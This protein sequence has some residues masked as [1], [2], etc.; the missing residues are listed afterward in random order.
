MGDAD[1][2]GAVGLFGTGFGCSLF[3]LLLL[4]LVVFLEGEDD[5]RINTVGGLPAR[6]GAVPVVEVGQVARARPTQFPIVGQ[7]VF[8]GRL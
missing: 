7:I 8:F 4:A 6:L 3:L 5:A 2:S 1:T